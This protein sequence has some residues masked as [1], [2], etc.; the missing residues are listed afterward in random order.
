M[1]KLQK[2]IVYPLMGLSMLA[3]NPYSAN[4]KNKVPE[5]MPKAFYFSGIK[6]VNGDGKI[7]YP[8]DY[9]NV[10]KFKDGQIAKYFTEEAYLAVKEGTTFSNPS[11]INGTNK[12]SKKAGKINLEAISTTPNYKI[13]K[14]KEMNDKV[15]VYW[16]KFSSRVGGSV[17]WARPSEFPKDSTKVKK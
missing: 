7:D 16:V 15:D 13:F 14:F 5:K 2:A 3:A 12:Q 11:F 6:D 8:T 4:A 10:I 1:N 9:E 17:V